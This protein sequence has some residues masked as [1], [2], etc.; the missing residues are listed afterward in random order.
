MSH[1]SGVFDQFPGLERT[2]PEILKAWLGQEF[3][4]NFLTNF[5]GNRVLYPHAI[6]L[7]KKEQQIDLAILSA[8]IR[9]RPSLVFQP[10]TNKIVIPRAIAERFPVMDEMVKAIIEGISPKGVHF[11][12][13]KGATG[14]RDKAMKIVGSVIS[15]LNPQK[16][17]QDEKTVLFTTGNTRLALP[18]NAISIVKLSLSET[19][20]VLG[21][22]EFKAIG[23]DTGFIIDL[24]LGGFG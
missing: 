20:V 9:S 16:L 8:G 22:E 6:P 24:R 15:P 1:L 14:D 10:Q 12:Y 18:L 17:S 11:I 2:A 23:G 13:I 3:D 19:K 21:T 4:S 7:T 5:L